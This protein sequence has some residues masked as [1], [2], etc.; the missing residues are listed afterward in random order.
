[1]IRKRPDPADGRRVLVEVT[2]RGDAMLRKLSLMHRQQLE[3]AG[4]ELIRALR[5]LLVTNKRNS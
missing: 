3:G 2:R 4:R 1:L 5:K